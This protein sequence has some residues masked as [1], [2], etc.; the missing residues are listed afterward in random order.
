MALAGNANVGKSVIFNELTG[1]HQHVGN[2]PGKTVERAEGTLVFKGYTIDVI[3]L[4]GIYSLST[5]S[6]EELVS[7]EHI[8]V[9][10]PDVLVNVVDASTLERNLFFTVQLLE[11][12]PR[13][14]LALNQVDV[15]EK[16]GIRIDA[17]KL[18]E[19]LGVSVVPMVAVKG[20][21]L[22]EL[23]TAT[24][25]AAEGGQDPPAL[26]PY[27][28]EIEDRIQRLAEMIE[29]IESPYPSRWLAIKLFEGD[30]AMSGRLYSLEPSLEASVK[31]IAREIE[32]I[33]G[34]DA[35]SVIA[36]E[37]YAV[38][39]RIAASV[40]IHREAE[41]RRGQ[42]LE[43]LTSHPVLGYAFMFGVILAVF[44][45]VFT[46]GDHL[47][48]VMD[49]FFRALRG[50]YEAGVGAGPV[51]D[52]VWDGLIEGVAAGVTIA[53]PY[54]V[55]FYLALSVLEDSGY[56]ARIAFLMDSAMHRIGLHGK[57][58]I[59]LML[60]FGCSVPATLGCRIMETE[61]ERLICAFTASIVPCAARS[62]VIMGL[63]AEYVGF[64]WAITLYLLDFA[65]IFVLGRIAFKALPGEPM[66]LI[67]EMPS[68]R[69]PTV[70]VTVRRAWIR[71]EN[72]VKEAFPIMVAG[73]I[74]IHLAGLAGLLDSVQWLLKPITVGWLGL[75][76]AVGVT[77]I[78]GVLRKELTLILL[79]SMLGTA[80]FAQVL[81]PVQMFVFAFVVMIYVP[82]I[83]TIG[84]L[85]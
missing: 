53:L 81:T 28:S 65:L 20:V 38:A 5:Y 30:E 6:M 72:F 52:F 35:S 85:V 56:L 4:P 33:H 37:R 1:L 2:W 24:V 83:A 13:M 47:T 54:I 79:A 69:M 82:C 40:T 66:G 19:E 80:N 70:N 68:Y 7:R 15:A 39:S 64:E 75:P 17:V 48:G 14:I 55:P 27:G 63:V 67:M 61:R 36:S 59:P 44:F 11:L 78:F 57:G 10:R 73:N 62:V 42:R 74:V 26:I 41:R 9:E 22:Q 60:G 25:A 46:L 23:M 71:M 16:Q 21:G 3:D 49:A 29:G 84:A 31:G 45:G 58:F 43:D 76:A 12:E 32:E 8:A 34:H 50:V 18:S 51:Q 77:L